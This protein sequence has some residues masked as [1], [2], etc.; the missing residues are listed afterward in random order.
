MKE[1][2]KI[3]QYITSER[4]FYAI[5]C[6]NAEASGN[7]PSKIDTDFELKNYGNASKFGNP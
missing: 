2:F 3:C 1:R 6:H 7:H 5:D 4:T